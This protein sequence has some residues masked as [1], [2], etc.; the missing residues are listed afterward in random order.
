MADFEGGPFIMRGM[1]VEQ[2]TDFPMEGL[3]ESVRFLSHEK[4]GHT[5][6]EVKIKPGQQR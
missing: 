5:R 2:C 3:I 4:P 6:C 1:T